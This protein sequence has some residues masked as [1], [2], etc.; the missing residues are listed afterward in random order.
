MSG[1]EEWSDWIDHDGRGCPASLIGSFVKLELR[2]ARHDEDGGAPGQIVYNEIWVSDGI[3]YL[4]EWD[5]SRFGEVVTCPFRC[6]PY[7]V[8]DVLR[9]R[10]RKPRGL[11]Q[12]EEILERL[13]APE[14][15]PA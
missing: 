4:P 2:L 10:I 3:E 1:R 6:V 5:R 15:V 13:D 14:E 9:Y 8:A 12:L 7:A 11:V